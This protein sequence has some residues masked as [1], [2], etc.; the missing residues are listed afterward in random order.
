MAVLRRL[1]PR[2][3][4]AP[5]TSPLPRP[6][7]PVCV[8]GDIHGRLDLL[9]DLLALIAA[10]GPVR[11]IFA[12]DY[13]DRGPDSAGVLRRLM[14][15]AG[16]VCLMGNHER[17]L[18]DFLDRPAEAGGLWLRNGGG[19]TAASLGITGRLPGATSAARMEALAL[20][21][22]AALPE[23]AEAWLRGLPL[24]WQ[25]GGLGVVHA[26]ADPERGLAGQE[27]GVLLW[28]HRD[29]RRPRPDGLW[30]GHGHVIVEEPTAENGRISV[31]T[32]AWKTG[33]LTAALI[34]AQGVR[35]LQT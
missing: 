15:L 32:G 13:I 34:S 10:E 25:E 20:R 35:F 31:D 1:L 12:G 30:I 7:T 19:E 8:I 27:D 9:E 2:L 14:A 17:M 22:R 11:L 33:K 5:P 3:F 24:W 23:G 29:F 16:A 28:G 26:G 4:S 21:V 18:L 6:I